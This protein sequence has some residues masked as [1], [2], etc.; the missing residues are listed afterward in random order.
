MLAVKGPSG[1]IL[2]KYLNIVDGRVALRDVLADHP[3][4][5]NDI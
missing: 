4:T 3:I 2:P 1:G 5:W